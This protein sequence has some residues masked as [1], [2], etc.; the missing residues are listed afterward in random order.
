MGFIW[1]RA[2]HRE[3]Y[4]G[5]R[6]GKFVKQRRSSLCTL[7]QVPLGYFQSD[8]YLLRF[9]QDQWRKLV[10]AQIQPKKIEK[11]GVVGKLL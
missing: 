2:T 10:E 3:I 4:L 11:P 5:R 6:F 8:Y 7:V 1:L 9:Q